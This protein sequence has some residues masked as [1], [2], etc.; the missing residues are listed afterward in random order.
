[1]VES[2]RE[3]PA[4]PDAHRALSAPEREYIDAARTRAFILYEGTQVR[5][6]SCGIAIAET[7]GLPTQAYQALRRGGITG[8]GTCGALRAGEQVLG[9]LLGDPD[10]AGAVTPVLRAAIGWY[11]TEA[12]RRVD[13]GGAP[14]TIC[15]NLVRPHGEFTGPRRAAFCTALAAQV[16]E[17]TAE[18]VIRFAPDLARA[19][20][21]AP[22]VPEET[23]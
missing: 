19:R 5:H 7:F 18:A 16:A 15:N 10:P 17:L 9:E 23:S 4:P 12:E 3:A 11:Q 21:I 6:R 8:A 2:R 14:D 22:V 1:M 20:P 13:R